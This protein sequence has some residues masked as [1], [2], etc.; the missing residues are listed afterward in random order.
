[1]EFI[2]YFKVLRRR[3][4]YATRHE[5]DF[6]LIQWGSPTVAPQLFAVYSNLER[7][8]DFESIYVGK[9]V[10]QAHGLFVFFKY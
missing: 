1:V 2:G 8:V 5:L 7:S 4:V 3:S 9:S 6:G 10:N